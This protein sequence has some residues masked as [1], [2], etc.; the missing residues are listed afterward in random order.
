VIEE[1]GQLFVRIFISDGSYADA[2]LIGTWDAFVHQLV[3]HGC[4]ITS[5]IWINR[6]SIT[7][8]VLMT[9]VDANFDAPN[10]IAFPE[11]KGSA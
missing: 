4:V 9:T 3:T 1:A 11:P 7:K 2:K 5:N 10:V 8:M 6:V